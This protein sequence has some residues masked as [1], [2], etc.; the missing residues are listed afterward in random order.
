MRV[1]FACLGERGSIEDTS[2]TLRGEH[3]VS[4]ARFVQFALSLGVASALLGA[5]SSSVSRLAA[6]PSIPS[7]AVG[8]NSDWPILLERPNGSNRGE[9]A[10]ASALGGRHSWMAPDAKKNQLLYISDVAASA[11][12][13]YSYPYYKLKGTLT[14][15]SPPEGEC[16]DK[17]ADVF[18]AQPNGGTIVEYA[19][20]GA[21]PIA[22]LS[23]PGYMPVNCAI[24]PKTGD[25]A[26]ANY[27]T[28]SG[29]QG[30]IALYAGAKG[31]PVAYYADPLIQVM[32][33]C[34]YDNAGN[35]FVD[36]QKLGSGFVLAELPN[37]ATSFQNIAVKQHFVR[38]GGI[39]WDG[40]H[41][42]VGDLGTSVIYQFSIS[43]K[44]ATE[45]GSTPLVGGGE[46]PQF[47]IAQPKVIG[48]DNTNADVGIWNYPAGGAA[49]KLLKNFSAPSGA[50]IS[51]IKI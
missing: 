20:G 7:N 8:R 19:H 30:N 33:F 17:A 34:G 47:W 49:V 28:G 3:L 23:D 12:Y 51:A 2:V 18:V 35:L 15:S 22:T 5:C 39:Q 21:L 25:L 4:V 36:G 44:K 40:K 50:A 48:P 31:N 9:N 24:D 43:G 38:P 41:L 6:T 16:V 27:T 13:V 45:A 10:S 32:F 26:V 46:I 42:A 14:L 11:V 37:G 29:G 1:L